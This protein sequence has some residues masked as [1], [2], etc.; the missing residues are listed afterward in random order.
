MGVVTDAKSRPLLYD[1]T[2]ENFTIMEGIVTAKNKKVLDLAS[3]RVLEGLGKD[4]PTL[5]QEVLS[6][7]KQRRAKRT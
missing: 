6:E 5:H 2:K 7:S 3:R 4:F 1:H